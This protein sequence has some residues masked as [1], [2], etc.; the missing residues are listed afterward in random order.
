MER[1][2]RH[3]QSQ[4]RWG[5]NSANISAAGRTRTGAR[6]RDGDCTEPGRADWQSCA[7]SGFGLSSALKPTNNIRARVLLN[8]KLPSSS[9]WGKLVSPGK[10]QQ[11]IW[12]GE[13]ESPD[14][15]LHQ[16]R[17]AN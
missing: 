1:D 17:D 2:K 6:A 7:N 13:K 9:V 12:A 11:Q 4:T 16:H 14:D 15:K 10:P 3:H 5:C 8:A